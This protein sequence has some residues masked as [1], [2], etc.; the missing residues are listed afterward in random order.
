MAFGAGNKGHTIV[1]PQLALGAGN[2]G[3]TIIRPTVKPVK[4]TG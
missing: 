4:K 2:K 1:R 3:H